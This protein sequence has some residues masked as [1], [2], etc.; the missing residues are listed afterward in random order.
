MGFEEGDVGGELVVIE[1]PASRERGQ[2]DLERGDAESCR[3]S[4][5][6]LLH[7]EIISLRRG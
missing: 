6:A 1:L 2:Q 7:G 5:S 3:D 4:C